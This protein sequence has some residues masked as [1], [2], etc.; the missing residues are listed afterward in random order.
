MGVG[1]AIRILRTRPIVPLTLL[2]NISRIPLLVP[3]ESSHS[4]DS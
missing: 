3:F 1:R 4:V 2:L